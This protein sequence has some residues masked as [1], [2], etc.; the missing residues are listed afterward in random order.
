MSIST[1]SSGTASSGAVMTMSAWAPPL[2]GLDH[3]PVAGSATS[4][5]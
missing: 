5:A 1:N 3:V 4:V 2:P